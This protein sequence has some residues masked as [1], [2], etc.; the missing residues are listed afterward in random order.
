MQK[1]AF[2]FMNQIL[3]DGFFGLAHYPIYNKMYH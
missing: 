2:D 3:L 1:K